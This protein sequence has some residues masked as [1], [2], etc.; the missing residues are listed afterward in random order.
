[1]S[2]RQWI[3]FGV[4]ATVAIAM[5]VG[6]RGSDKE[7][8]A[9]FSSAV[10]LYPK[11]EVRVLGVKVGTVT[12]VEPQGEV[13]KVTLKIEDDQP[14]PAD[15][16]AAIIAPNLVN[17]RFVQLAP[18][19]DGGKKLTDGDE[20]PVER[21]AVPISFDE[22][23]Q[24]LTDLSTA[25]TANEAGQAPLSD[26]ITAL[27]GNLTGGTAQSLA[28]SLA[29]L[30]EAATDLSSD[31]GDIFSTIDQLNTFTENL[32]VNDAALR[33]A[34][35]D[36]ETFAGTLDGSSEQ[37]GA[38]IGTLQVALADVGTFVQQNRATVATTFDQLVPVAETVANQ[39]NDLAQ[40][41]HLAPAAVEN[42]YGT[43]ENSAITGRLAL[44]NLNSTGELLCGLVLTIGSNA[45]ACRQA[46]SPLFELIGLEPLPLSPGTAE[47]SQP[48]PGSPPQAPAATGATP[49][50]TNPLAQLLAPLGLLTTGGAR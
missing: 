45:E 23:K 32:V 43:V 26:V 15:A 38:A 13:V 22:V 24:E 40:L 42:F 47:L 28:T 19:Y 44:A 48:E 41:L 2:I 33:S 14:I 7:V 11:D 21:T 12:K 3:A 16:Q 31:S 39:S 10:G 36:L 49:T 17:G 46:L 29:S 4:V 34:T 30:R 50:P 9:Y 18:I 27:D 1:V 5:L 25:L 20:I 6:V 37:I 8:T 35:Q